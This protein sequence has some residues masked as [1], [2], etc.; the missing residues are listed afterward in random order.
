MENYLQCNPKSKKL[1][2]KVHTKV[3]NQN[4]Y[5]WARDESKHIR[6]QQTFTV[7]ESM[8]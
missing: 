6:N 8:I 2:I 1:N 5:K 3:N 4:V 7:L